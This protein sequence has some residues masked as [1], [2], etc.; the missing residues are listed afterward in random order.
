MKKLLFIFLALGLFFTDL[1]FAFPDIDRTCKD[2]DRRYLDSIN[3]YARRPIRVNQVGFRPQDP[4]KYGLAADYPE[5]TKFKVIDANSGASAWEGVITPLVENAPKS[6]MYVK[7]A[8]NS[9]S[10]VYHFQVGTMDTV[11]E[12]KPREDG[13]GADTITYYTAKEKENVSRVDFSDLQTPGKYYIVIGKDTSASFFIDEEIY[14]AIFENALKFFGIQRCGNTNS[15]MHKACHLKDG[16]AVKHDLTGGWHDCGDHFKVS[17]TLGYAAYALATTYLVYQDKAED[18]YGNSYDDTVFTD[19]IPDVLYEAK[20]G[21]DFIYKLYKASKADGLI[22]KND[23]YH[24]VAV[25]DA[26]HQF[27]D[28]PEK[29]D[30]QAPE[31]GG[32]NRP[33]AT[34][35]GTISGIYAAA[36]AYFAMGWQ[37]Y[38]ANYADSLIEAA[39]D[40]YANVM[41]PTFP[42]KA[43]QLYGFYN[44]GTTITNEIDD[45]AAAALAL[46][47][48]TKDPT[49]QNDLYKNTAINDNSTNYGYNN[50]PNDAGPYFKAGYLGLQSGFYPGGWV[51]DYENIHSYV[52]FSFVKLILSNKNTAQAYGVGELERDTLLQR[53]TNS[54]RRLTD[55]GT[56]GDSIVYTNRFG[57]LTVVK[58]Y[59]LVWTSSHWGFNRYDMGAANAV[60]M[61]SEITSGE[62][63][64]KYLSVALDNFYY[65]LGG[66]PWDI[67]FLMGAGEKNLNHPHNRTANPDGYNAGSLPYK[68]RCPRGALMGGTDPASFLL[69]DWSDYTATETCIDFSTQLLIPAQSLAKVLPVDNDGPMFSNIVGVPI[70]DTS[71]VVSW[72]ADEVALVTV[73]YNTSPDADGAKSVAQVNPTKGGSVVLPGLALGQTY[74]FF[75][76]GMDTKR[77]LTTDDNHGQWYSFVMTGASTNIS[78][79]VI[80]QVDDHSAKIYWWTSDRT[81]GMVNFGTQSKNY[82]NTQAATE[83]AVLFHEV[84]LT[85]LT[86]GTTYYFNVASGT[87]TSTEKSFTTEQYASFPDLSV[88]IKP[89]SKNSSC[90]NWEDCNTFF[91][92]VA[93]N[94]TIVY[95]DLEIRFYVKNPMSCVSY[96]QN[97]LD[98]KGYPTGEQNGISVTCGSAVSEPVSGGYYVPMTL[99]GHLYVSGSYQFELKFDK[100]F[101]DMDGSWT[102]A[103]H[104]QE[105]DPEKFKGIDLT[106]GPHYSQSESQYVETVNGVNEE[107]YTLDPYVTAHYHGKYI[108]GYGPDYDPDANNGPQMPRT[109]SI[110]FT[111]PFVSPRYSVEKVDY[112][113]TYTGSSTV[114]PNGNLDALEKN[115]VQ[116]GF[117]YD[118]PPKKDKIFFSED[119]TLT[120]GN[121]YIEWVSWHNRN[122]NSN[123]ENKYDCAC[124]VV[125]S[126][127]EIDTITTPLLQRFLNFDKSEYTAYTGKITEVK[128][129]LLDT[130]FMVIDSVTMTLDISTESGIPQ[131]FTTATST[132]P[133]TSITLQNG[134]ATFYVKS[135]DSTSTMIYAYGQKSTKYE[136]VP[137]SAKLTIQQLPPWPI[138]DV[139]KMIDT[140]CDNIPDAFDIMLSN[141]Y[142]DGK[143]FN[144]IAFTYGTDSLTSANVISQDGKHIVVA[145]GIKDTAVN[146][147]PSGKITLNSN[148]DGA[149]KSEPDFYSDGMPPTLVSISVLERLDTAQSDRVYLQFSEPI[150][151]PG[152]E[153][154]IQLYAT[155]GQSTTPA[156]DVKFS[157][158]YNDSLNI[159]EFE[160]AFA[161]DNSSLVKENMFGQLLANKGIEDKAG[162]QVSAT[163]GQPKL[164]IALKILPIPMTYASISDQDED[165]IAEYT[166]IEFIQAVDQKHVPEKV[167]IIFGTSAPET[168]WVAGSEMT[169]NAE[170]TAASISKP[171]SYGVTNGEYN[172]LHK[173]TELVGAGMVIQHLG[174]GAA[175]ES[176]N[177]LAED[178]AGPVFVSADLVSEG[179]EVLSL[180]SSEPLLVVDSN[181]TLYMRERDMKSIYRTQ[182]TPTISQENTLIKT[183]Y[184]SESDIAVIEGDRVKFAPLTESAFSDKSG[185]LPITNNPWVTVGSNSSPK[186]KI[187]ISL[188]GDVIPVNSKISTEQETAPISRAYIL[189]PTTH[190]LDLIEN[191]IVIAAGRDT[192]LEPLNGIVWTIDMSVPRG[193]SLNEAAAWKNLT[194][195]YDIPVY[196]NLGTFVNRIHGTYNLTPDTYLSNTNKVTLYIEWVN[197]YQKGVRSQE[198]KAVGT[199]AYIYK[200]DISCRFDPNPEKDQETQ[201]RFT[202]KSSKDKTQ[203]FGIKRIK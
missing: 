20:I 189:N 199:G 120:L 159:W 12:I 177:I 203:V 119:T 129:E 166:Q 38:D 185:N 92:L 35:I 122:A 138:I 45:A 71:A 50:E 134:R 49:Y 98:G 103:P 201:E 36:L 1:V 195:K 190:K 171:F 26:D 93:N 107:A 66:N 65:N 42:R 163:C 4:H 146:T 173:G 80:C 22:A 165:G 58:P 110:S 25:S 40:I 90:S 43:D 149:V 182:V 200:A 68:Y 100:T 69:D 170:R 179:I 193:S 6:G 158:I 181:A 116:T 144:S 131:I 169:F 10:D 184:T 53:A 62:E 111:S 33:V 198:G 150:S 125:R 44:G 161:S 76:E 86:P 132:V 160:I 153:W 28:V 87:S 72:D 31:K 157:K 180:Y 14:N 139:A 55:D 174:T 48:A 152:N 13:N 105:S 99:H 164:P 167:S 187:D 155:D 154:P 162:N 191:G 73:F 16:S 168:L 52:L 143:T 175:Y 183:R 23:M 142:T 46:W 8:F 140:D 124:A 101:K 128:V 5:G 145:A 56:Q 176:N 197:V 54:L 112:L 97:I 94:D 156:P 148:V 77:N 89:T 96:M 41:K 83:G 172:G 24:S 29:Q 123:A 64:E 63:K 151:A 117:L 2:C 82:T 186:I 104:T 11:K 91:V 127:V 51:T 88:Y 60:F 136:Y 115:G 188:N 74:Y 61:M 39:K 78:D 192:L 81:N 147:V 95:E 18:R 15:Q 7:G 178:K 114:S 84:T 109:V 27:W 202:S 194:V 3:V 37:I 196:T 59:N 75:L 108:Y 102:F 113:T 57:N 32:P 126:N 133:V 17:E 70:S 34:G 30:V 9:I 121:N 130:N 19:G 79:P 85:G 118:N 47:Y 135:E 106:R 137:A 67:S 141:E 21:V